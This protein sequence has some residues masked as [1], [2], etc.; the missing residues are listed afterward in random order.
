VLL[1]SQK[2]QETVRQT[3][4]GCDKEIDDLLPEDRLSPETMTSAKALIWGVRGND[5]SEG[6]GNGLPFLERKRPFAVKRR[7]RNSPHRGEKR[8]KRYLFSV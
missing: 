3:I 7:R 6:E 1:S 2:S 4:L 8:S 5:E